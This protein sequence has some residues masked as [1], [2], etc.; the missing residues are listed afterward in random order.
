MPVPSKIER[1][2][3]GDRAEQVSSSGAVGNHW[4]LGFSLTR[5]QS[6]ETDKLVLT[7]APEELQYRFHTQAE[8]NDVAL[9]P[10]RFKAEDPED[11]ELPWQIVGFLSDE[12]DGDRWSFA[13]DCTSATWS[14]S[15]NWP[16]I[17][18]LK[19]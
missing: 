16:E 12:I 14:W 11:L 7:I 5:D 2:L 19:V 8:F 3:Y 6:T 4:V 9:S 18:S 15:S 13:L 17:V 1:A 10:V